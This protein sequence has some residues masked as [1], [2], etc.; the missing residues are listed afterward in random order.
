MSDY[1]PMTI[2]AE[3]IAELAAGMHLLKSG[4]VE[5]YHLLISAAI[6]YTGERDSN[7]SPYLG[8]SGYISRNW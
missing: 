5:V 8:E 2:V 3:T 4:Y 7:V 1:D 6:S